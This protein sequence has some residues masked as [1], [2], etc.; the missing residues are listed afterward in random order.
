M[1]PLD[2][3]NELSLLSICVPVNHYWSGT[4]RHHVEPLEPASESPKGPPF[5]F[6]EMSR[7]QKEMGWARIHEIEDKSGFEI[8]VLSLWVVWT[9]L[10]GFDTTEIHGLGPVLSSKCLL[11]P[12]KTK[13]RCPKQGVPNPEVI[14]I[15]LPFS[16]KN[17]GFQTFGFT[18]SSL[19]KQQLKTQLSSFF[20]S[21]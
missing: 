10:D 6:C 15:Y 8:R 16:T 19:R 4:K 1:E 5:I 11:L 12:V 2:P 18:S 14:H 3:K 17:N 9:V 7:V 13:L 20:S 21:S